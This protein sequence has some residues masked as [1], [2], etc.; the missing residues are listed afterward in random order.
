MAQR[1]QLSSLS[2]GNLLSE[3]KQ[4]LVRWPLFLASLL[5]CL[6]IAYVYIQ[7]TAPV[8]EAN[9]SIFIPDDKQGD[10]MLRNT[11]FSDLNMFRQPRTAN[12]E[13]EMLRSKDLVYSTL[14]KLNMGVSLFDAS[15]FPEKELYKASSPLVVEAVKLNPG[16]YAGRWKIVARYHDSFELV[17]EKLNTSLVYPLGELIKTP[18][19]EIIVRRNM[20][21]AGPQD[22]EFNLRVKFVDLDKLASSYSRVRLQILP[23]QRE[24][25][26]IRFTL[27]DAIPE[28]ATDII[29][30]LITEYR[31]RG[32][33]TKNAMAMSNL[34]MIDQRLNSMQTSL[35]H[36]ETDLERYKKLNNS[37][38]LSEA[39]TQIN[40]SKSADYIQQIDNVV[41]QIGAINALRDFLSA[42]NFQTRVIPGSMGLKDPVLVSLVNRFNDLQV[43][44]NR[45]LNGLEPG[46]PIVQGLDE[47]INALRTDI[48]SNLSLVEKALYIE[49]RRL[50][51]MAS[52]YRGRLD[53][54]PTVQRGITEKSRQQSARSDN[55]QYLLQKKEETTLSLL[56]AA[57]TFQIVERANIFPDPVSPRVPLCY[58]LAGFMGILLPASGIYLRGLL[59]NKV[60][61][62]ESIQE[63]VSIPVLGHL[64]H[65][66][67]K[68]G[69]A[70]EPK[71]YT[72]ISELFRYIRNS[73]LLSQTEATKVIMVT[74]AAQGEGKTFFCMNFALSFALINKRVVVLEFDLR[75]PDLLNRLKINAALGLGNYLE[76]EAC[77]PAGIVIASGINPNLFVIGAGQ[78]SGNPSEL[79]ME[80]DK[81]S[82]LFSWLEARYDYII[83][84]TPPV[85]AVSDAL[86]ISDHAQLSVFLVRYNYTQRH[87]LDML[88][89]MN[90]RNRLK[91]PMMVLNDARPQNGS[92]Y[93]HAYSSY[94]NY[95]KAI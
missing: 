52:D 20:A 6:G 78:L 56:S 95:K 43:E 15:L 53:K 57:P 86:C 44:R 26:I 50:Q 7:Y 31:L 14:R 87:H 30:G 64:V 13:L 21:Y 68:Y 75:R 89:D 94:N 60:H 24:S 19:F 54:T 10:G 40:L 92:Y 76:D 34:S 36:S 12:D 67:E 83:V 42:Q 72:A 66:K 47:Q 23:V 25:N 41:I 80:R 27:K 29:D 93:G 4:Y 65:H 49:K 90:L 33:E 22:K 3:M 63:M 8:Y 51:Q 9:A 17:N 85:G 91:N 37:A 58:M 88:N 48:R 61:D 73:L 18:S 62:A 69:L 32:Q 2:D 74:S 39:G 79:L 70:V 28:R 45:L 46:S 84:D 81:M 77:D 5:I 71:N 1:S 16:A 59:N 82:A 55:Y 11:A 38:L 35:S